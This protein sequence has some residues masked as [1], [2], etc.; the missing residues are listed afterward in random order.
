[1]VLSHIY[2]NV[3]SNYSN[4]F[5]FQE[6]ADSSKICLGFRLLFGFMLGLRLDNTHIFHSRTE[7]PNT[8]TVANVTVLSILLGAE[9][10]LH[11]QAPRVSIIDLLCMLHCLNICTQVNMMS[12]HPAK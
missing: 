11:P 9:T 5:P 8:I 2:G 6:R 7:L 12:M 10:A 3:M 1:M 4:S